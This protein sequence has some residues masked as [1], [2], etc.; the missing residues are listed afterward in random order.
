M[1]SVGPDDKVV[2]RLRALVP[3]ITPLPWRVDETP[4]GHRLLWNHSRR[5]SVAKVFCELDAEY[6]CL[7]ANAAPALLAEVERLRDEVD[8]EHCRAEYAEGHVDMLEKGFDPRVAMLE[9][10]LLRLKQGGGEP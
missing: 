5:S 2:A 7:A 6:L 8:R 3:E 4:T 9:V 1:L 10:E